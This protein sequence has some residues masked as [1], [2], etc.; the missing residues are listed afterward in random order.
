[1]NESPVNG[2]PVSGAQLPAVE[3]P[4]QPVAEVRET[5]WYG[6][7]LVHHGWVIRRVGVRGGCGFFV[8][9][10]PGGRA[11]TVCAGQ[12]GPGSD[13]V[14]QFADGITALAG[15]GAR[16]GR[17]HLR[18][19]ARLLSAH[20]VPRRP[21]GRRW[22]TWHIPGVAPAE[23][24]VAVVRAAYWIAATLTDDYGWELSDFGSPAAAG[25]FVADIP[26]DTIVIFP[27]A[28]TDDGTTAAALARL[29]AGV[30]YVQNHRLA[31]LIAWHAAA[32]AGHH[33][34]HRTPRR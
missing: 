16:D 19:L 29:L 20:P 17:D 11:L 5:Y 31:T 34:F 24:P 28:M 32:G 22:C 26:G 23:Q 8:A 2:W 1:M 4:G 6:T 15:L 10:T 9:E 27:A 30:D 25:G 14:M 33:R 12:G 7:R 3:E 18:D 21:A 13:L